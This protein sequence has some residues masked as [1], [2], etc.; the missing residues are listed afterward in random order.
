MEDG[1][2]AAHRGR[3]SSL[4][5]DGSARD[6]ARVSADFARTCGGR[7]REVMVNQG[8]NTKH[9]L[10]S[11]ERYRSGAGAFFMEGADK[12]RAC[13]RTVWRF[14]FKDKER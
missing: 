5:C 12:I 4:G 13:W 1:L 6:S 8:G 10:S 7:N 14:V 11:L 3:G 2:G 9:S